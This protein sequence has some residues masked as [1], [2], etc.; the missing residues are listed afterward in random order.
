VPD[1]RGGHIDESLLVVVQGAPR[2]VAVR[3][4]GLP[5][6]ARYRLLWD[7]AHP[8][9]PGHEQGPAETQEPAG[10]LLTVDASSIR[11]YGVEGEGDPDRS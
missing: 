1:G 4:P 7:S 9:P 8:Y 10:T 11:V 6:A 5:W 2:E 3:L